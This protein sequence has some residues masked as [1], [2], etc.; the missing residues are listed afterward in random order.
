[1]SDNP[2]WQEIERVEKYGAF[3][4]KDNEKMTKIVVDY[5]REVNYNK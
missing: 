5:F 3:L 1:M 2:L 4:D